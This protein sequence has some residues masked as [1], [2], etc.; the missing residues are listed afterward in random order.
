MNRK[1]LAAQ[2]LLALAREMLAEEEHP[3][4]EHF[5]E[6]MEEHGIDSPAELK[7]DEEKKDFF[8]EVKDE[9]KDHPENEGK[10]EQAR[11][12]AARKAR[13]LRAK[14][15]EVRLKGEQTKKLADKI[16]AAIE[17]NTSMTVEDF[18]I[19]SDGTVTFMAMG[20]ESDVGSDAV[21]KFKDEM[22]RADW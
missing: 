21:K 18:T 5:R 7:T 11:R 3:Y 16:W 22:A 13:M 2:Q 12:S 6:N 14:R 19:S 1:Q 4:H 15:A 20:D 17:K 9:W 10:Q 8:E